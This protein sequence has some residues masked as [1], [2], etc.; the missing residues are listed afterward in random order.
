MTR[1][2][3]CI[4]AE[5]CK[6]ERPPLCV[7]QSQ[8]RELATISVNTGVCRTDTP[9]LVGTEAQRTCSELPRTRSLALLR[10]ANA[11]R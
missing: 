8:E 6:D 4:A 5:D 1:H 2:V 9:Y 3:A 11:D 10:A 7:L